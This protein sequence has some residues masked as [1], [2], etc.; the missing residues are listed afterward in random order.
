MSYIK[1]SCPKNNNCIT[2]TIFQI[3][4]GYNSG[5]YFNSDFPVNSE[6]IIYFTVYKDGLPPESQYVTIINGQSTSGS[7]D[8]GSVQ[9]TDVVVNYVTPPYDGT[10]IY[11]GNCPTQ[12]NINCLSTNIYTIPP[13]HTNNAVQVISNTSVETDVT[14]TVRSKVNGVYYN[15][16]LVISSGSNFSNSVN[17]GNSVTVE[18]SVITNVSPSSFNNVIYWTCSATLPEA[19]P[20]SASASISTQSFSI[21]YRLTGSIGGQLVITKPS[22]P[23]FDTITL[24]TNGSN[25]YGNIVVT[26]GDY[27]I[28]GNNT[29]TNGTSIVKYNIYDSDYNYTIFE[30]N[31]ISIINQETAP[32][33]T[34][35]QNGINNICVSLAVDGN[36]YPCLILEE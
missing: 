34:F 11:N 35:S 4:T 1:V 13:S 23:L 9:I 12:Q 10:F 25:Q 26:A 22:D 32:D 15:N 21:N 18:E 19:A 31:Q 28:T 20:A 7:Y 8:F 33:V 6:I 17:F 16:I 27:I 30:S 14:V 36:P 29:R 2:P 24:N 3:H 5:V